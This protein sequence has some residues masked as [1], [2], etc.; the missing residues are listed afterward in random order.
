MPVLLLEYRKGNL[1]KI[2]IR[3]FNIRNIN[4]ERASQKH[5]VLPMNFRRNLI[6]FHDSPNLKIYE[7]RK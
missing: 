7:N 3:Y 2:F 6:E 5:F 4:G 1:V